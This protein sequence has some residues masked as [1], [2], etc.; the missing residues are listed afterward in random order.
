MVEYLLTRVVAADWQLNLLHFQLYSKRRR[1][2]M[3][4]K[5]L[6]KNLSESL[7]YQL[8][9]TVLRLKILFYLETRE[10]SVC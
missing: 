10:I 7:D 5:C 8:Y 4:L 9:C 3:F 6:P 1:M 2:K